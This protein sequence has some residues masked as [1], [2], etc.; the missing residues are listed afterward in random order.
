GKPLGD[1][2]RE[3]GLSAA[4]LTGLEQPALAAQTSSDIA[5]AAFAAEKGKLVGP[6]RSALGWTLLSV[7][8]IRTVPGK[9][10]DQARAELVPQLRAEKAAQLFADFVNDIDGKLGE[11]ATLAEVAKANELAVVETP[12]LTAQGRNLAD[13]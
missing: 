3:A 11:G 13:P 9:T 8:D 4:R 12:L 5:K 2:A 10:L 7:D 1:L 6:V